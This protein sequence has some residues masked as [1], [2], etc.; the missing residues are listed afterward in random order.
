MKKSKNNEQ[1]TKGIMEGWSYSIIP[2]LKVI[3]GGIIC[4]E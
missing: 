2:D 1:K 4:I 3:K